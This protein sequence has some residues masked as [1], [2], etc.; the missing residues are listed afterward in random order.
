M[1][2]API[3]VP[4]RIPDLLQQDPIGLPFLILVSSHDG[5]KN[6]E[7]IHTPEEILAD[8]LFQH[9]IV[10]IMRR[11]GDHFSVKLASHLIIQR[12]VAVKAIR[13]VLAQ[14]RNCPFW[15]RISGKAE[16]NYRQLE[17]Q[18]EVHPR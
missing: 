4:Q 1:E 5:F 17:V 11:H 16:S 9:D 6:V 2:P 10:T 18:K 13:R 7:N 12:R 15:R 8:K 14:F 3:W